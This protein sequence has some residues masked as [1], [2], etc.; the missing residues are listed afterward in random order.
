MPKRNFK[1]CCFQYMVFLC[2]NHFYRSLWIEDVLS[3][4]FDSESSKIENKGKIITYMEV[5]TEGLNFK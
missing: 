1:V 3:L 5:F 4:C 2:L